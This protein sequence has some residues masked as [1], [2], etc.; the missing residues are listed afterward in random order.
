M[1]NSVRTLQTTSGKLVAKTRYTIVKVDPDTKYQGSERI[2]IGV[3]DIERPPILTGVVVST[4]PGRWVR[5]V[6]EPSPYKAGERVTFCRG[7]GYASW[8]E[9]GEEYRVLETFEQL[10]GYVL[11]GDAINVRQKLVCQ[12]GVMD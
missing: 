6:F 11:E 4:G 10:L 1:N 7:E 2:L 8:F 3:S 9:D 12:H 5:Q